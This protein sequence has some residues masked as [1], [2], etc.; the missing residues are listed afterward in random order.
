MEERLEFVIGQLDEVLS[1]YNANHIDSTSN[2]YLKLIGIKGSLIGLLSNTDD[3]T[4]IALR[5]RIAMLT[6]D[7]DN[8]KLTG[9]SQF[10]ELEQLRKQCIEL[11][12]DN[13][14]LFDEL[15]TLKES[16]NELHQ[17]MKVELLKSVLQHYDV[18][19][20]LSVVGNMLKEKE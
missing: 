13:T 1:I 2:L 3:E 18:A 4:V 17:Q 10:I 7:L 6:S 9:Q 15:E 12:T 5:N 14:R 11:D 8:A 19:D 20:V 16:F